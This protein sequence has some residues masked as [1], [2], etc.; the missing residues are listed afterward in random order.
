LV[1]KQY[2]T[3][4]KIPIVLLILVLCILSIGILGYENRRLEQQVFELTNE[5]EATKLSLGNN[6]SELRGIIASTSADRD[7]LL[8]ELNSERAMVQAL[9]G[10]V[11]N[12]SGDVG[13]LV[14]LS[15]TDPELLKKYSKVYFLNENYVP[16]KLISVNTKYTYAQSEQF[17]E[18]NAW[19]FLQTLLD[20]ATSSGIDLKIASGY[21]SFDSQVG[22]KSSYKVTFGAGTANSFSADQGYSEHQLGTAADFTTSLLGANFGTLDK[23]EAYKWLTNNAYKYGFILSYPKNNSYYIYEPW[24]WRFVGKALAQKLYDEHKNFYD[25]DQREID[26]H[27]IYFFDP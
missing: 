18:G 12:I 9:S 13:K 10:Q 25:L 4:D 23:T 11:Q 6:I 7:R 5:L 16:P 8:T 2:V 17:F 20:T 22:L 1:E 3:P 21:R 14:K 26:T 15:K 27:L 24:H 19:P